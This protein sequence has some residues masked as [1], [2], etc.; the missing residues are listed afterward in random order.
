MANSEILYG[1]NSTVKFTDAE[2]IHHLG[3]TLDCARRENDRIILQNTNL[4]K[5]GYRI[6]IC[7]C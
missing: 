1:P 4:E 7:A 5:E 2:M 3:T 6:K